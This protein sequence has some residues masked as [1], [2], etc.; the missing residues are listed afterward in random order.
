MSPETLFSLCNGAAVIGWL[1]L[2]FLFRIPW[3]PKIV[4]PVVLPGL[5]GL[6]YAYFILLE[7]P[8]ADG[9][10]GSLAGVLQLFENQY[11]LLAAWVHYL[12]FDLF[13]GS[14]EVRDAQRRA[15]SHWLVVPCLLLTFFL[16]PIGLLCYLVLRLGIRRQVS[17]GENYV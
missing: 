17:L 8:W 7:L 5:F 16:G 12:A 1:L 9:G 15:I 2:L 14:W 6:I 10:F 4:V 11:L 13:V 3:V